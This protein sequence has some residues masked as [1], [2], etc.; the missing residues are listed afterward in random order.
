VRCSIKG[1]QRFSS[2][3]DF[4]EE[5][6]G[7]NQRGV[8]TGNRT[9][10]AQEVGSERRKKGRNGCSIPIFRL[11]NACPQTWGERGGGRDREKGGKFS[12]KGEGRSQ[13]LSKNLK[14]DLDLSFFKDLRRKA[15]E[16]GSR[17]N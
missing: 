15:T 9:L 10:G 16:G 13:K 7:E 12:P 3:S 4:G 6:H 2:S 14:G 11:Y 8:D 5:G 17:K 1:G